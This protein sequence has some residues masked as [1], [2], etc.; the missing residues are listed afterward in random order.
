MIIK[1][2]LL[3]QKTRKMRRDNQKSIRQNRF[4]NRQGHTC[5]Y[6]NR[7]IEQYLYCAFLKSKY[8]STEKNQLMSSDSQAKKFI[9]KK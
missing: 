2:S 3:N 5:S 8:T 6:H 4:R 1:L 7:L 9:A